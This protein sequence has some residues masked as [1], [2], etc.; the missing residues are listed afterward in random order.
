[1]DGDV[2]RTW[3]TGHASPGFIGLD[4]GDDRELSGVVLVVRGDGPAEHVIETSEDGARFVPLAVLTG[5]L[6]DSDAYAVVFPKTASAGPLRVTTRQTER[7]LAWREIVPI[8]CGEA[9]LQPELRP[10]RVGAADREN[11]GPETAEDR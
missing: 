4:F 7:E 10:E 6:R 9:A 11:S 1:F 5:R 2:C 8:A 3:N